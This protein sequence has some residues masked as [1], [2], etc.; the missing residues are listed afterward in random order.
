MGLQDTLDKNNILHKEIG[1][2]KRKL[3]ETELST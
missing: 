2:L 3:E 1:R